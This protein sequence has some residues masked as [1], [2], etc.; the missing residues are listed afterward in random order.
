MK[1]F[2]QWKAII[3]KLQYS[4]QLFHEF[5]LNRNQDKFGLSSV[6]ARRRT[7]LLGVGSLRYLRSRCLSD[8]TLLRLAWRSRK[9]WRFRTLSRMWR[10]KTWMMSWMRASSP[11]RWICRK[12]RASSNATW[13]QS[14]SRRKQ[15][16]C[17]QNISTCWLSA[18][19]AVG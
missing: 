8:L 11:K 2:Q 10:R 14:C 1:H 12:L 13:A 18:H 19:S 4:L 16:I 3:N 15:A 17:I 5:S 7:G 9:M 6:A